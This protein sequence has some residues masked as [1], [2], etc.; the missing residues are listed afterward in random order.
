MKKINPTTTTT[1]ATSETPIYSGSISC[2]AKTVEK[3]APCNNKAYYSVVVVD[4]VN[5]NGKRPLSGQGKE[6][7]KRYLCGVHSKKHKSDR[8]VLPKDPEW[9]EKLQKQYMRFYELAQEAAKQ[10]YPNR[11][12]LIVSKF[13]MMKS[14]TNEPGFH[15][16]FPN[17]RHAHRSD[18]IGCA[19]LSPKSLGPVLHGMNELP[20]ALNLENFHQAA[21]VF[22]HEVDKDGKVTEESIQLRRKLY[23]DREPHRHK[24]TRKEIEKSWKLVGKHNKDINVNLPLFS[25]Y[26]DKDG[27]ERRY[28]YIQSRYFYCHWYE[29]LAK[30]QPEYILLIDLLKQG[31]NLQIVGY[32]GYPVTK[33]L[34]THYLDPDKPFGH[35]LVLYSMLYF[36]NE[37]EKYPWNQYY[38]KYH[39]IYDGV[40]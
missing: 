12:K 9:K 19:T 25:L 7:S 35:E 40:I 2:E 5:L 4:V 33:D 24:F 16:I 30:R 15:M 1:I 23:L 27:N 10:N 20:P 39:S 32:D 8:Q 26:Y 22:P 37:T 31:Y 38:Q 18:G 11:G 29:T 14:P 21:K 6:T 13:R 28:T 36:H 17:Y 34:Y 3:N